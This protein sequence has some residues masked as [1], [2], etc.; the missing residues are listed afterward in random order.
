MHQRDR[1]G[2]IL[3]AEQRVD[4]VEDGGVRAHEDR[5]RV[6][7]VLRLGEQVVGQGGGVDVALGDDD[8]LAG[9][10]DAVDP[11]G[12]EHLALG[13]LHPGAPRAGDDGDGGDR[14]GSERQG[15]D[16][17]WASD[18]GDL[19]D[20]EQRGR[21]QHHRRRAAV[22]SRR[23]DDRDA[24]HPR[25]L[26][27]NGAHDQARRIRR[28]TAGNVD[29]RRCDGNGAHRDA[30]A[31]R[32]GGADVCGAR[33]DGESAH[34]CDGGQERVA[35]RRV[36]R[37]CRCVEV[38]SRNPD[39]LVR[40]VGA[41]EAPGRVD[42]R[43]VAASADVGEDLLDALGDLRVR[44]RRR[45]AVGQGPGPAAPQGHASHRAHAEPASSR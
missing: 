6:G 32:K 5:R 43:L 39:L 10:G 1:A 11:D 4:R 41:V 7:T 27:G 34:L 29:A 28:A 17:R 14:V 40:E 20:A 44:R 9:T 24:L 42:Q 31:E 30:L 3:P 16:C 22:G 23:R 2:S 19:V 36:E 35:Q 13:L 12:A 26:R 18:G 25:F 8:H 21:R 37:G 33:G 15:A 45:E 38:G